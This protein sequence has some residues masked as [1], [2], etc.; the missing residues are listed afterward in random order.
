VRVR[1][2]VRVRGSRLEGACAAVRVRVRVG[3]RD[4]V[5]G[6]RLEAACAAVVDHAQQACNRIGDA[7]CNSW[8][9]SVPL[10]Y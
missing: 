4:R 3:V 5:R 9:Y 10:G 6:G 8:G 1:V 2:R 7:G